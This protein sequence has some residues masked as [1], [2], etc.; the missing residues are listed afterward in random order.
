MW[1]DAGQVPMP[2][3]VERLE[4]RSIGERV[5]VS[6]IAVGLLNPRSLAHV[7]RHGDDRALERRVI[8]PAQAERGLAPWHGPGS[9]LRRSAFDDVS[10]VADPTVSA[11]SGYSIALKRA[12]WCF[13]YEP[14]PLVRV[15]AADSLQPYLAGRRQRSLRALEELGLAW[16]TSGV[17]WPARR[18]ALAAAVA[19][20][21]G[22][23]QLGMLM[24]LVACS[25]VGRLPVVADN[26]WV[27]L[28]M[29]A[30]WAGSVVARLALAAG[31]MSLGDWA[32]HGW[33]T[34]GADIAAL[35]PRFAKPLQVLHPR[36]ALAH[37]GSLGRMQLL[38]VTFA[39]F[40]LAVAARALTAL[41]PILL[42]AMSRR[43][44]A[45]L[46]VVCIGATIGLVAVVGGLARDQ[47]RR[48]SPRVELQTEITV[49]GTSGTTIDITPSGLGALVEPAPPVGTVAPIR[50]VITGRD[51]I[52]RPV[53]ATGGI[54]S[55]TVHESGSVRVGIEFD[56]IAVEHRMAIT[57]FCAL[58]SFDPEAGGRTSADH[59]VSEVSLGQLA[60]VRALAALSVL[61]AAGAV[62]LGPRADVVAA[63]STTE[64][65]PVFTP[66]AGG[67][68][69]APNP[70]LRVRLHTDAW[71]EPLTA[72]ADG[73]FERG[74]APSSWEGSV[75]VEIALGD[76]RHVHTVAADGTLR[77]GVVDVAESVSATVVGPGGRRRPVTAGDPLIP[78]PYTVGWSVENR[79]PR[80]VAVQVGG[81]QI[82]QI[83]ADGVTVVAVQP[84]ETDRF[85]PVGGG[86]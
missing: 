32:K 57:D 59:L 1:L 85:E 66:T 9:I 65:P 40:E 41:S 47:G 54:R 11:L 26:G 51:G 71:S 62:M 29:A 16:T 34:L 76:D 70:E 23:R 84:E 38:T 74:K 68:R 82:L 49:A 58:G 33:R 43:D 77:L 13:D 28:S 20:T 30:F 31:T 5:A 79:E 61:V 12:G 52:E 8:G 50:F 46:L 69:V 37:R 7:N 22:I 35:T 10:P 3:M 60:M 56:D 44:S 24:I 64:I 72:T 83:R 6:Q 2:D 17:P 36:L 75:Y 86:G 4:G 25:V 78:G 48:R 19:A 14:R 63:E 27:L 21:Q 67:E 53:E 39:V 42:P 81:D 80:T 15:P 55:A 45:V 18:A 73:A